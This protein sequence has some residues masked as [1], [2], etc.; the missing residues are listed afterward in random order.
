[1]PME[2][3]MRQKYI[4]IAYT[5]AKRL[6]KLIEDLFGFTKMNCGKIAMH[7]GPGGHRKAPGTASGGVLSQLCR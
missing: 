5:K 6:E 3:E 4:D 2:E 1:M 7:V